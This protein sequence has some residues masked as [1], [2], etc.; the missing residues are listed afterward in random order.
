MSGSHFRPT[1]VLHLVTST[2]VCQPRGD[3]VT[4]NNTVESERAYHFMKAFDIAAVHAL[5]ACMTRVR[6]QLC[7]SGDTVARGWQTVR[8]RYKM[9]YISGRKWDPDIF[10]S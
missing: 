6:T 7:C 9:K 4:G 3:R 8:A 10:R 1:D 5:L 2:H